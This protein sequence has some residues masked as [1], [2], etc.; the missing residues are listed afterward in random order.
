MNV[1]KIQKMIESAEK[2]ADAAGYNYQCT[3]LS[4]YDRTRRDNED[5]AEILRIAL[6]ANDEH[7]QLISIRSDIATLAGAAEQAVHHHN[8]SDGTSVL[9]NLIAVASTYGVYERRY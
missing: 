8:I 1:K 4:R 2:R 7:T 6:N 3:G 5:L 9:N